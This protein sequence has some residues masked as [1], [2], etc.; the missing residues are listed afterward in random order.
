[1]ENKTTLE[2]ENTTYHLANS[3]S[4]GDGDLYRFF[5]GAYGDY[6]VMVWAYSVEDALEEAAD[7]LKE[8]APGLLVNDAELKELFEEAKGEIEGFDPED[9]DMV[10]QAWEAATEDLTYTESGHIASYEWF[11]NDVGTEEP[12]YIAVVAAVPREDDCE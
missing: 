3:A 6:A 1:M 10:R 11:V 9:D 12:L 5:F 4:T 8:H 7:Y 2:F